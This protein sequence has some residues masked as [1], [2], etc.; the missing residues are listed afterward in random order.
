[1][2]LI[3]LSGH[4]V[5]GVGEVE[6]GG[7]D[8]V[9]LLTVAW[10]RVGHLDDIE[11]FWAAEAGDLHSVHDGEARALACAR[12]REKR[13]PSGDVGAGPGQGVAHETA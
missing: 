11:D 4:P 10:D 6:A 13:R 1:V 2:L 9:E 5:V 8:V 12:S 7:G 3:Y